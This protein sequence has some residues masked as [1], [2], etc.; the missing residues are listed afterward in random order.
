MSFFKILHCLFWTWSPESSASLAWHAGSL[1]IRLLMSLVLDSYTFLWSS[2]AARVLR[3]GLRLCI[4]CTGVCLLIPTLLFR[5]SFLWEAD[6]T[7][8]LTNPGCCKG[9]SFPLHTFIRGLSRA[10]CA[11]L[12]M[13][14]VSSW[15]T[16][17]VLIST[18]PVSSTKSTLW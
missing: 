2:S 10:F 13:S 6:P 14:S 1:E 9:P 16:S 3:C 11:L 5:P 8:L 17:I 7:Y 12:W 18:S 4:N 15:M